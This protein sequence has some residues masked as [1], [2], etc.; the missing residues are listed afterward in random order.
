[1]EPRGPEP[2]TS[3]STDA[4][5]Q[6][7]AI[8]W[9]IR[10]RGDDLAPGERRA[11]EVWWGES[12]AHANSFERVSKV[13][14]DPALHAAANQAAQKS[15]RAFGVVKS[16]NVRRRIVV[17]SAVAACLLL[18]VAIAT[19]FDLLISS[20]ADYHTIAGERRTIELPD[21]S[22]VTLNTQSAIAVSF[23]ESMRRVR[24]LEGEAFF[25]VWRDPD[26][27]FVVE[28]VRTATRA[29]GTAF[30][31]RTDRSH[32]E[33]TVLEGLVEVDS[34]A[35]SGSGLR[36]TAGS[37]VQASGGRMG[38]PFAT[39]LSTAAAWL[40]GRLIVNGMPFAQV[41]D[42]LQR[43]YPGTI[44]LWN[45]RVGEMQVTGTFNLDDPSKALSLLIKTFP[46]RM[47]DLS[48]RFVLLY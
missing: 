24:L 31:V 29:I 43:Y 36:V 7:E 23:E 2:I 41:L 17:G 9:V 4:G 47:I 11:F 8:A 25:K 1:M 34:L 35:T 21:R 13:W 39:N 22:T 37:R 40:K 19:N 38:Q 28:A 46:V 5:I 15:T 26:R 12:P 42:E 3:P 18:L 27:P 16:G 6:H 32:D 30:V 33:V 48:D 44:V 20:P 45:R 10:L 14:D